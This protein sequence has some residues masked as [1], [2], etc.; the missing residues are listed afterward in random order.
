LSSLFLATNRIEDI[1][2]LSGLV[3]LQA[4][5][6]WE[7][8]ISDLSPL[9][10][11]TELRYLHISNNS[12]DDFSPLENMTGLVIVNN[13]QSPKCG[14]CNGW[15]VDWWDT[16]S[17]WCYYCGVICNDCDGICHCNETIVTEPEEEVNPPT[18]VT[19]AIV[20][21]LLAGF[22]TLVSRKKR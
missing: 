15:V 16:M 1:S 8:G 9:S 21:M 5:L 3:N 19:I 11:L 12:I 22:V 7:N 18:A 17:K 13:G 6:I 14:M 2:I 20:P 4:L 10:G